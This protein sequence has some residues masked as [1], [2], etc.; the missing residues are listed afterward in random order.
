MIGTAIR[1]YAEA[2]GMTC[3]GGYAYG[4]VN[5]RHIAMLDGYGVKMLQIYLHP[6][7]CPMDENM[8]AQIR[9]ALSDCDMREY[10]L[11]RGDAVNVEK[12]RAVIVFQ[13]CPGSIKRVERYIDEI[14]PRLNSIDLKGNECACC[15]ESLHDDVCYLRM[16]DYIMPL[17]SHCIERMAERADLG[18]SRQREGSLARG[19]LGAILG[20]LLGAI[21]WVIVHVLGYVAGF[22]GWIIGGF[23]NFFYKRFGGKDS[24]ARIAVVLAAVVLGVILGQVAGTSI[25]FA[26]N[27]AEEGGMDVFGMTRAQY[28]AT[29]WDQY[30]IEDQTAM[31]SNAYDRKLSNL[32]EDMR[33][34]CMSR[35]EFIEF[36][37]NEGYAVYRVGAVQELFCDIGV[38]L[39][40]GFIGCIGLFTRF[41]H[42]TAAGN[43]RKLKGFK[44]T[45]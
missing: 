35:S 36:E 18:S 44:G 2:H 20:A 6:P 32:S 31:L 26:H 11:I 21:P 8:L 12:G 15:A 23:A 3:D 37:W 1:K 34:Q 7:A 25:I 14:M 22:A 17:H 28:I 42:K 40:F 45:L 5:G 16:D 10:R 41:G 33:E 39:I 9:R 43:I 4:K 13:D 38:G 29:C 30:L 27:Y 24:R 19:I